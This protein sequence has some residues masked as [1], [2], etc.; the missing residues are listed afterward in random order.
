MKNA[1]R[2]QEEILKLI[3][4]LRTRLSCIEEKKN[5]VMEDLR[6]HLEGRTKDAVKNLSN[7]RCSDAIKSRFTSWTSDEVPKAFFAQ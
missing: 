3:T 2:D 6:T 4:T 1:T 7:Y 5:E